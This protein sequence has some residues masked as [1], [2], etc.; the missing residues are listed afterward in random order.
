MHSDVHVSNTWILYATTWKLQV[1]RLKIIL[2]ALKSTLLL[3]SDR[4]P[5]GSS[6]Y[7]TSTDW[8]D[9]HEQ[10]REPVLPRMTASR[11]GRPS[12]QGDATEWGVCVCVASREAR[13]RGTSEQWSAT[14]VCFKSARLR[15]SG[16]VAKTSRQAFCLL[17][18]EPRKSQSV[19]I[20]AGTSTGLNHGWRWAN[21]KQRKPWHGFWQVL[22]IYSPERGGNRTG[23]GSV[24]SQV[25]PRKG[26]GVFI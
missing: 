24:L 22:K 5:A 9:K 15:A 8:G 10:R 13:V 3:T 2:C 26:S 16:K 17:T 21:W 25:D 4:W 11:E 19:E 12:Q 14:N 6:I 23:M 1:V 7:L 20:P 18:L